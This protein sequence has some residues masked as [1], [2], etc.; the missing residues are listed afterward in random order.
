MRTT[1]LEELAVSERIV[2]DGHEVVPRFRVISPEGQW[3]IFVQLPDDLAERARRFNLV[4]AFMAWK[5]ATGFILCNEL[6]QP[7]S[8]SAAYIGRDDCA[9]VLRKI[10]RKP[11]SFSE[12]IWLDR[13]AIGDEVIALLPPRELEIDAVQAAELQRLFGI[14]GELE[15]RR[16]N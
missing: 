8:I 10:N 15:A 4:S 3:I 9:L 6:Y 12:P 7:D 1:M 16:V 14:G 11:L 2:R 13:G 5:L